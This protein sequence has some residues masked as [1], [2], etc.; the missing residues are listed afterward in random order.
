MNFNDQSFPEE[1]SLFPPHSEVKK[2]LHRYAEELSP[3]IQYQSL[4][5]GVSKP[6]SEWNVQWQDL[7]TNKIKSS[8]FDAIVVANGHHNDPNIPAIPGL[9]EWNS[10]YPGSVLHSSSY[11]RP[12]TFANKVSRAMN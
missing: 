5:L 1:T 6:A 10:A 4:V 11:R 12:G 7:K 2:Y 8:N 9:A 3:F